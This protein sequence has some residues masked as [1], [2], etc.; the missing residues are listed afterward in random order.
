MNT[1]EDEPRN[2]QNTRTEARSFYFFR[3]SRSSCISR[4]KFPSRHR[5][6]SSAARNPKPLPDFTVRCQIPTT[7]TRF[8]RFLWE[9][10]IRCQISA[11]ATRNRCP[12]PDSDIRCQKTPS[13]ANF[14][15][16][17]A[18]NGVRPQKTLQKRRNMLKNVRFGG[19]QQKR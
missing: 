13:A 19:N 15:R 17:P 14:R 8:R 6:T 2:T 9:N 12:L 4:L 10:D 5:K 18:E 11:F 1:A 3:L 7:A 16:F